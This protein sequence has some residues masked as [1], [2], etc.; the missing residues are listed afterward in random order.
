MVVENVGIWY[1]A[2]DLSGYRTI[3]S[4]NLYVSQD[5]KLYLMECFED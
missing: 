1:V 3:P 4:D 5:G 2:Q